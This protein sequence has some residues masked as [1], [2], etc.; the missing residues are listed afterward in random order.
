MMLLKCY[1][2][3]KNDVVLTWEDIRSYFNED[4]DIHEIASKYGISD[5]EGLKEVLL[6]IYHA[7]GVAT[8]PDDSKY[9]QIFW[10]LMCDK[11]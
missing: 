9:I 5:I 8:L 3:I 11:F 1:V 10:K 7:E 2:V 6:D 4:G